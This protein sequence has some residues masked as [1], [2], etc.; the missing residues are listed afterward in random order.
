MQ[1]VEM[2]SQIKMWPKGLSGNSG[3]T[4]SS[5]LQRTCARLFCLSCDNPGLSAD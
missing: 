1:E 5:D 3:N 4:D 2:F